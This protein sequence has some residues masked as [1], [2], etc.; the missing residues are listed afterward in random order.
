MND[1]CQ[2]FEQLI[3]L[4]AAGWLSDTEAAEL[5]QHLAN[6]PACQAQARLAES[7]AA[8]LSELPVPAAPVIDIAS[9]PARASVSP[10]R[11][12]VLL[13][14]AA[15]LMLV[16]LL[17]EEAAGPAPEPA[18]SQVEAL[19]AAPPTLAT[20]RSAATLSDAELDELLTAHDRQ[21]P[22]YEPRVTLLASRQIQ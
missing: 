22:F 14:A 2:D 7:A 17:P 6:C 11:L 4:K 8:L 9:L 1:P 16:F 18:P 10:W 5:D 20:Y 3:D 21:I 19:A 12:A 15:V 13:A